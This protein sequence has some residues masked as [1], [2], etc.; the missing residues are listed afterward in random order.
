MKN[1]ILGMTGGAI[2]IYLIVFCLSVYSISARKNEMENCISQVLEQNL[3]SYYGGERSDAEVRS[4]VT[5]DLIGR[6]Q[7]DSKTVIDVHTCDMRQG[8]LAATIREEFFLPIGTSKTITCSKTVIVEEEETEI[9]TETESDGEND[10][11]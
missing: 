8:I 9:T 6:L 3:L 1:I 4:V 5:Q 11:E 10:G 2:V 7:A